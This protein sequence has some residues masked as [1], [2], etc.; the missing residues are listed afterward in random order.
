MA[1]SGAGVSLF[2]VG[3][4]F[5]T[6]GSRLAAFLTEPTPNSNPALVSDFT[7]FEKATLE[8]AHSSRRTPTSRQRN[9]IPDVE[10][11]E[12]VNMCMRK[13]WR[14]YQKGLEEWIADLLQP[15]FDTYINE[16]DGP[17]ILRRIRIAEFHLNHEAPVFQD[18]QR[19]TSRKDSDLN[20]IFSVRYTGGAKMLLVLELKKVTASSCL[21]FLQ[22]DF[23]D[24]R[25][26][27]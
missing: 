17:S 25:T 21:L 12:W 7:D 14:V 13:V 2:L 20:G 18:M 5:A 22:S 26:E 27:L 3:A 6:L 24:S 10:S 4:A 9:V 15:V 8:S 23:T 1:V 11:V 19:R 16:E